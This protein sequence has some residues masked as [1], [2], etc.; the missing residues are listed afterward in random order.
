MRKRGR[1]RIRERSPKDAITRGKRGRG[2]PWLLATLAV[3]VAALVLVL[4]SPDKGP[5]DGPPPGEDGPGRVYHDVGIPLDDLDPQARWY[6]DSSGGTE[7]RFFTVLGE[8][9]TPRVALDACDVCHSKRLGFHQE[10]GTMRCNSCG[11]AFN[12]EGIGSQNLPDTCWPGFVP[13]QE[14]EGFLLIDTGYLD[15][16]AYMFE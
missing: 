11:K 5:T 4:A 7:V 8:D 2:P 1:S 9:G 13:H 6:T 16:K 3:V 10:G 14:S 12:V 15:G